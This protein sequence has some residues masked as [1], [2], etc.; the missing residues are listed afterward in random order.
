M[1]FGSPVSE[2]NLEGFLGVDPKLRLRDKRKLLETLCLRLTEPLRAVLAQAL[3][4][5]NAENCIVVRE[6]LLARS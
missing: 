1:G 6:V 4:C 3:N 5:T 2:T